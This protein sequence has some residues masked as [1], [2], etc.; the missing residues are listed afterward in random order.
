MET[1]FYKTPED[2]F[3][4]AL[5]SAYSVLNYDG[6]GNILLSSE[7]ASDDCFGGGGIADN[8]LIQWDNFITYTDHNAAAWKK[9]YTGIYRANVFLEQDRRR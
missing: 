8:G 6:Y 3:E 5:V 9:Y 2:A 4:R 7:I 1:D